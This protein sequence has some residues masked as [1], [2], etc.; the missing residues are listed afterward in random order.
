[1]AKAAYAAYSAAV[2]AAEEF[3]SAETTRKERE[4][5]RL[6]D[7]ANALVAEAQAA[8][9]VVQCEMRGRDVKLEEQVGGLLLAA[10]R[11]M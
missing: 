5:R 7:A 4:C 10:L 2:N 1:M 3:P 11:L 6:V 9:D 8:A